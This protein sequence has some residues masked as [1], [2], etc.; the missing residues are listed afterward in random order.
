MSLSYYY[1]LS[2]TTFS[3]ILKKKKL[4]PHDNIQNNSKNYVLEYLLYIKPNI[5]HQFLYVYK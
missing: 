3:H 2:D 1:K 5:I 4:I